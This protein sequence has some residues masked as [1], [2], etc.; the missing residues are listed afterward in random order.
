MD[1]DPKIFLAHILA[2]VRL[3]ESYTKGKSEADFV[4]SVP[5]QD[6]VIRR[7]EIVGEAV[8]HLP[9]TLRQSYPETPWRQIAG[10][11]DKFIH[12]YF[13]VDMALTWGIVK[14]DLPR[15]KKQIL[16]IERDLQKNKAKK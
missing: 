9:E 7:L 16:K 11:R 12:E 10:T 5:L 8:R 3:I 6:K 13:G 2:S 4:R 15:L 1:K 14:R